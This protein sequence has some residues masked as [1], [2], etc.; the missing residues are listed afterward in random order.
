MKTALVV[1]P[2]DAKSLA[3]AIERIL[4]DKKLA[5]QL[6]QNARK[7]VEERYNIKINALE[8]AKHFS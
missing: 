5:L 2:K 1:S 7:L 3:T 8:V 4:R 6:R